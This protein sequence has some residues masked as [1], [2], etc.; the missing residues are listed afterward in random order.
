MQAPI[1]VDYS[2]S[3]VPYVIMNKLNSLPDTVACDFEA[4]LR[5]TPEHLAEVRAY[6][7]AN[8]D[9]P[10]YQQ[11]I[12]RAK[13]KATALSHPY[14]VWVTHLSI[15]WSESE[16][17]VAILDKQSTRDL[18]FNWL[19]TTDRKQIW[20]NASFDFK[21]LHY[22]T[23]K[24]PPSFEDTQLLAKTLV[25]HVDVWRANTGLKE[26]A[27]HRYGSWGVS[28]E[29]FTLANLHDETLLKYAATDSCATY[30][31]WEAINRKIKEE[32]T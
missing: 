17:F 20:H 25:N 29:L 14:Y 7:D 30:F 16:S 15:A 13:L 2:Y 4:A 24:F 11:T 6:L 31:L 19:V 28:S 10:K 12:L 5:Y 23:N 22:R 9:L 26:L 27:G 18:V 8:P 3:S 32:S 1:E 21:H